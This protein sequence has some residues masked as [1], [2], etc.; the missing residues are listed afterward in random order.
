MRFSF[1]ARCWILA[2]VCWG[3]A[4]VGWA[5][6][7]MEA[8]GRGVVAIHQ[9]NG[10]VFVS[11]RLLA[12]D[13]EDVAFHLYRAEGA[14]AAVRLT[15]EAI[16]RGTNFVDQTATLQV[17]TTYFVRPVV[18]GVEGPPSG[19][20][21]LVANAPVRAYQSIA[22]QV[23]SGGVTP[24]GVAF[25]YSANDCSPGDL[26]GDGEYELVVKWDPSNAKDNSQSGYTGNV[27][28]DAYRL[29]GTRLWRI[30]L[31][32][33]IR[34][35][36]H[37]TQFMVYDLDGDG[38]AEVACKTADGTVDGRGVVIGSSAADHRNS[39]GYILA[40]PEYLTV[41][42][43]RTG[44]ALATTDYLPGRGSVSAWGD[45]YGNRVD[46]FLACVAYL[47]GSR[48]SLV[49]CRGY[50]TRAVLVAW[51]WR[52][53]V[54]S[55]RWTFDSD[56]GTPGNSAYRG[57]GNH[58]L[59]VADVDEDGRDEIV[60]GSC[61]IDDTGRGLYTTGLHH[62]DALHVS[63]HAPDRPGLE[64]W[65]CHEDIANNGGIGL[66]LRDARTG[67]RIFTVPSSSDTG[68]AVAMDIDP[69]HRGA[70][71]WGAAGGLYAADGT[72][73][74][75]SRPSSMNFAVWW[76]GDLL[77]EILDSNRIDKWNWTTGTT[78][79]LLTATD[80]TSNNGTKS[81]PALS[82]DLFGDWREEVVWRTSD[83][84]E[85]RIFSTT[86]ATEHRFVTLMHDPQYRLSV[87]WQNTA[88][89]QPPH[90]GYFLGDGMNRPPTPLI[91]TSSEAVSGRLANLSVRTRAGSADETLIVG[92]ASTGNG[93][94]QVLLRAVGPT[95]G[96]FDV[97]G[98]IAD[99]RLTL[100][101]STNALAMN[102]DWSPSASSSEVA[103]A[104]L[105]VGAFPLPSP[106][107]DAALLAL[108]PAGSFTAQVSPA[109]GVGGVALME[110]Y[111]LDAVVGPRLINAS[112][113]AKAGT[114]AETLIAGFTIEGKT[115]RTLLIRAVGPGLAPFG[116][117]GVMTDP[118][119]TLFR[120][121]TSIAFN[122]DWSLNSG[123]GGNA[124]SAMGAFPLVSGSKDAAL[125]VALA[126]GAYTVHVTGSMGGDGV[127]LVEL[128]DAENR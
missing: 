68:R 119:V 36:A 26:D 51:D 52:G 19:S 30:D 84:R 124:F 105:R 9:G 127:A 14:A 77:R 92:F 31:G 20:F 45:N 34:A 78:T 29:D 114:G 107:R 39:S 67:A 13:P 85:L 89:N 18:A 87:A 83:N 40:G 48:P 66:S 1:F 109:S 65:A 74:S 46:R 71:C 63:D 112:T 44:A 8:L 70:E 72:R 69:R 94:S 55:R 56:D 82:A 25:T 121:S 110:V 75:A 118:R 100:Y 32:K 50:Y 73:I 98:A 95:L 16:S 101:A 2:A 58:N 17:S 86:I 120:G 111:A 4:S 80:C 41:F 104:A 97:A 116:V 60:Y 122:D 49:M 90:P 61:V 6:R 23:P 103:A 81:T 76:D 79:R 93:E 21:A 106:S 47:D 11:W 35:G 53:G 115:V 99:P 102:D 62:G 43:G 10:K 57:Q 37:Y 123:V 27:F 3:S 117:G 125:L 126:P 24:D 38:R 59:A 33:N 12:S 22:L 54:L 7:E 15:A 91:R 108:L 64:V 128:Y 42:D 96:V 5:V 88:Y 113:R 28:L